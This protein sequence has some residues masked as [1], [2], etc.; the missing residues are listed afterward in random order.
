MKKNPNKKSASIIDYPFTNPNK[1][2][3]PEKRITKFN[4]AEYYNKISKWI[5]PYIEN[6]PLT[7]VRCPQ[8]REKKCFYQKHL[9]DKTAK[10]LYS[11]VIQEKNGKQPYLY[12]K[13]QDGLMSLVQ[14]D[15][16]EIHTWGCHIDNIEKPNIITL[17]L[18][19]GP[20][21]EWKKLI[22]TAFL[23]KESLEKMQIIS[24][25]KTTGGKGLH[26]VLPIKR[27]YK[28]SDIEIF[29]HT[30]VNHLVSLNPD[31]Y[32]ATM[33]K[34][35]RK[36]KI[37]LD[38]LRNQ[39]GATTIAPYSTRARENAPVSTPLSWDELSTKIKS[40][41]F[42]IKNLPERLHNL[43]KD[44]WEDFFTI[45]QQLKLTKIKI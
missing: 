43:K 32:I 27:Q 5:L 33:S 45:H 26:V 20:A 9:N 29:A 40:N 35:K 2:L 11:I 31:L 41:T 1:I 22:E 15:V 8:G 13:N 28:W 12:I 10:G 17:D 16:L 34:S 25:V 7:I 37:Y 18:D 21:V 36:G 14:F 38:Y 30:F 23:I 44:P 6:R 19:P 42:T 24:F 3:Y 4:L 39:R